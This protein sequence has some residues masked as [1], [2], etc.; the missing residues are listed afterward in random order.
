MSLF[1]KRE[2]EVR[3]LIQQYFETVDEAFREFE[4]AMRCYLDVGDCEQFKDCDSRVRAAESKADDL[5]GEIEKML[6]SRSLLPESRGDILGLLEY[7]DKMPNLVETITF[8]CETQRIL[9]PDQFKPRIVELLEINIQAY[10][11]VRETVDRLF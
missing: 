1:F 6:Y 7:F 10:K 4:T 2:R 5:R 9:V 8:M 11:L 3:G